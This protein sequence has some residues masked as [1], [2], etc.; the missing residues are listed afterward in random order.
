VVFFQDENDEKQR[1]IEA[2]DKEI[3]TLKEEI[4]TLKSL[5][6]DS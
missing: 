5:F 4:K 3:D 6:V 1:I 2:N